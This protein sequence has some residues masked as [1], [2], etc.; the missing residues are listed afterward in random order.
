MGK[1]GLE[2]KENYMP[3]LIEKKKE[4]KHESDYLLKHKLIFLFKK[5]KNLNIEKDILFEFSIDYKIVSYDSL[6]K[7][8]DIKI[9]LMRT[10]IDTKTDDLTVLTM[11]EKPNDNSIMILVYLP[12]IRLH[13]F[14]NFFVFAFFT[15][16][17][18]ENAYY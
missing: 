5:N 16:L 6:E 8:L 3:I 7:L 2:S 11:F 12:K 9:S 15:P 10:K 17:N 14:T 13:C 18:I 4:T 1:E